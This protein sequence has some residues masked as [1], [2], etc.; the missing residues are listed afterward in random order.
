MYQ[1][2]VFFSNREEFYLTIGTT[3]LGSIVLYSYKK[4]IFFLKVV[5]CFYE[6]PRTNSDHFSFNL[7]VAC[8]A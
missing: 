6:K 1:A 3:V 8:S 2:T 5:L 4:N 7:Q